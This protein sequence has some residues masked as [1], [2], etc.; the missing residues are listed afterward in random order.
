[1][2]SFERL[3]KAEDKPTRANMMKQIRDMDLEP[4]PAKKKEEKSNSL[5]KGDTDY[6]KGPN[7]YSVERKPGESLEEHRA[8]VKAAR[9]KAGVDD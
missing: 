9:A 2:A 6:E 8:R 5:G 3:A 7:K 4:K 1:M